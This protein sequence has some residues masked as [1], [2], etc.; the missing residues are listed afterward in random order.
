[1]GWSWSVTSSICRPGY[2]SGWGLP[3]KDWL[4]RKVKTGWFWQRIPTLCGLTWNLVKAMNLRV[5]S[6]RAL[7]V[8][9]RWNKLICWLFYSSTKSAFYLYLHELTDLHSC[10]VVF[11]FYFFGLSYC[12][13]SKSKTLLSPLRH[14]GMVIPIPC[15]GTMGMTLERV[16]TVWISATSLGWSLCP[17]RGSQ[18]HAGSPSCVSWDLSCNSAFPGRER[19]ANRTALPQ[20]CCSALSR[21]CH[22]LINTFCPLLT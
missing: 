22:V 19:H 2:H 16:M 11:L 5:F 8:H 1:M 9:S 4:W 3:A 13:V 18:L 6:F 12:R 21:T 17:C 15:A 14:R 7:K 20:H 10:D